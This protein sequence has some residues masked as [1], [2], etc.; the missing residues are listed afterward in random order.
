MND[1]PIR[2]LAPADVEGYR[3]SQLPGLEEI[4]RGADASLILP[5]GAVFPGR[6]AV[7]IPPIAGEAV[8]TTAMGGYP[9]GM[10]DPSY[11]GQILVFTYPEVGIYGVDPED[12]ESA[13][14]WASVLVVHKAC[15]TPSL[16]GGRIPFLE[17]VA[18]AGRGVLEHVD[19]RALT[20]H[21]RV[22]GTAVALVV[23]GEPS[24]PEARRLVAR[25][26]APAPWPRASGALAAP[27]AGRV[28]IALVDFG[29]KDGIHRSLT[30]LGASVHRIDPELQRPADLLALAPHGVLLSNGPGD[31]G[32]LDTQV[33]F[34]Q[35]LLGKLPLMGICLGHQLLGRALGAS[36]EKL[37]FGHRGVNQPVMDLVRG[38]TLIT[39]Q[40]HGYALTRASLEA[41]PGVEVTHV[42]C[43]DGSVEGF[44]HPGLQVRSVQFHP[45]ARPGP[46]DAAYLFADFVASLEGAASA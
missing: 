9:E 25:F 40:N 42:H 45:E 11:R 39:S 43:G 28:R 41:I 16:M 31:P 1:P 13:G 4:P 2:P 34:V 32:Q 6:V 24:P 29:M 20:R 3:A 26:T 8:F 15:R 30:R 18:R 12:L 23:R 35:G 44:R 37:P 38:R 17:A 22:Q 36:T 5:D 33:A 27:G 21:L 14:I 19:T 46:V 10:T 7:A